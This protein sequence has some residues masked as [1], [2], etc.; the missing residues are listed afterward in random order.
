MRILQGCWDMFHR[1]DTDKDGLISCE[2]LHK[3]LLEFSED[4]SP[5]ES[6]R[7]FA[8]ADTSGNHVLGFAEFF[9]V[10]AC[11]VALREQFKVA[12][13]GQLQ[14]EQVKRG[15]LQ[16][17]LP[18]NRDQ[19][20]SMFVLC[21]NSTSKGERPPHHLSFAQLLGLYNSTAP[22]PSVTSHFITQWHAAAA[23]RLLPHMPGRAAG[24]EEIQ[25]FRR[26]P[27]PAEISPLEDFVSGT[28]AGVAITLVGHPFDTVKVRMQVSPAT[29]PDALSTTAMVLRNEGVTAFF[30]GMASPMASVPFINAIVFSSYAQGKDILH[31]LQGHQEPLSAWEISLAG[32]Y[33]GLASCFVS[34]PVELVKCKLQIQSNTVAVTPDKMFVSPMHCVEK[35]FRYN[36]LRGLYRGYVATVYREVPGFAAQFWCYELLKQKLAALPP[37]FS[38]PFSPPPPPPPHSAS[39]SAGAPSAPPQTSDLTAVRLVVAGGLAGIFGWVFSYPMDYVKTQLQAEP[40]N[41]PSKFRFNS[42]L[43]DGGFLDCW[44]RTVSTEGH[45]ALWRGF[46][47]C[48]V[49]AFPANG[50]GFLAYEWTMKMLRGLSE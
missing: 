27:P 42:V 39:S 38:S 30:K 1:L 43:F 14:A 23:R 20:E 8:A 50:A 10:Y 49:R 9:N 32:G 21:D 45:A 11:L 41:Q 2:D 17:G 25:D 31:S 35:I 44:R 6:M 12:H 29:Y 3:G 33:A 7:I 46:V 26:A 28:A 36:G 16:A 48:A 15:L 13:V 40:Y 18:A 37:L 34:T 19:V 47:P 22:V 24:G 5:E 4:F